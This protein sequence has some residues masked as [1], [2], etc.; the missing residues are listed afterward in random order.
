MK[1][2]VLVPLEDDLPL[3]SESIHTYAFHLLPLQYAFAD[4]R[5]LLHSDFDSHFESG[6]ECFFEVQLAPL[7]LKNFVGLADFHQVIKDLSVRLSGMDLD[8][9]QPSQELWTY[10]HR[11]VVVI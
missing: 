2:A 9:L 4:P 11:C 1:F 7:L 8:G 3:C 5:C 10:P 6:V